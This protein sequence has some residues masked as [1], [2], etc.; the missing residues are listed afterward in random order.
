M[1]IISSLLAASLFILVSLSSCKKDKGTDEENNPPGS[2]TLLKNNNWKVVASHSREKVLGVLAGSF[3]TSAFSLQ[4]ED[5]LR[6]YLWFSQMNS[7]SDPTEIILNTQGAVTVNKPPASA[8]TDFRAI[9]TIYEGNTWEVH[10]AF[11]GGSYIAVFKNNQDI[12]L[13]LGNRGTSIRVLKASE[14]GLLNQSEVPGGTNT[15]SHF[16]YGTSQ[17]KTNTFFASSF[18]SGRHN[19]KTYVISLSKN[20]AQDGLTLLTETNNQ[21]TSMQGMISYP[22]Q[23]QAHLAFSPVGFL[24]KATRHGDNVFVALDAYQ[25]KFEVY[26][27]SLTA[28]TIEK[29]LDQVKSGNYSELSLSEIDPEGNLYVVENRSQNGTPHFSIRKYKSAGGNELILREEDLRVQTWI[30]GLY[31]FNAKLHAAILYR[32]EFPG[33]TAK[34]NYHMQIICPK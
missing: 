10:R 21:Q 5:E 3:Y 9:K 23:P 12:N 29:V 32:E 7:N 2:I 34:N 26:K 31:F 16:H 20:T 14:D 24:V 30:H 13:Q 15:V 19:N 22:M 8:A 33:N 17:W 18:V 1:K 6:W 4:K 25:N 27:I 11:D 28:N